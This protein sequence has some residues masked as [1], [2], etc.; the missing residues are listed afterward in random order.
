MSS[1]DF[2]IREASQGDFDAVVAVEKAAFGHDEEAELVQALLSDASAQPVLSLLAY[3][4]AE[5][6]GHVLF[7][8]V[9]LG[10]PARNTSGRLL[11]PL[12]VVPQAQRRGVG[13]SLIREGFSRLKSDGVGLVFVLGD[14]RYYARHG[15]QAALPLGF[16]PPYLWPAYADAWMLTALG[17][18]PEADDYGT[19]VCAKSLDKPEYWKE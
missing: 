18:L 10:G 7:S 9:T 12:A 4:G 11:A 13:G 15:F 1:A 14:P 8:K 17:P 5:P 19:V 2:L 3:E 6:V 16:A